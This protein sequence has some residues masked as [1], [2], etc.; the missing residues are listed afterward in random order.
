MRKYINFFNSSYFST[1][2][3]SV[4]HPSI[5][6]ISLSVCRTAFLHSSPYTLVSNIS[7]LPREVRNNKRRTESLGMGC[8]RQTDRQTDSD[9]IS[10]SLTGGGIYISCL[11]ELPRLMHVWDET[12]PSAFAVSEWEVWKSVRRKGHLICWLQMS[13]MDVCIQSVCMYLFV[14]LS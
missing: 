10:G 9:M 2:H 8:G 14:Y 5:H 3:P 12:L 1:C 6:H 11:A 7:G 4:C 13:E